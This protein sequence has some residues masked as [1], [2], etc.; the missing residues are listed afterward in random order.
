MQKGAGCAERRTHTKKRKKSVNQFP[1]SAA[2]FIVGQGSRT[3]LCLDDRRGACGGVRVPLR[4]CLQT[5]SWCA[6]FLPL[7]PTLSFLSRHVPL[8]SKWIK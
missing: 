7:F 8:I 1:K 4:F 5:N 3:L 6:S 2:A